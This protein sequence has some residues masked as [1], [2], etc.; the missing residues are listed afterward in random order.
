MYLIFA[1]IDDLSFTPITSTDDSNNR[2]AICKSHREDTAINFTET[3]K[4][5]FGLAM[6]N[7]R[8]NYSQ[9]ISK[10]VLGAPKRNSMLVLIFSILFPDSNRSAH[11]PFTKITTW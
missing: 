9:W 5:F 1:L 2:D 4:P 11:L 8:R 3:I 6:G 7:I 10:S